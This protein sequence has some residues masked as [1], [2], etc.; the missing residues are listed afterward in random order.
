MDLRASSRLAKKPRLD[1]SSMD[2]SSSYNEEHVVKRL[3]LDLEPV[4]AEPLEAEPLETAPAETQ[5]IYKSNYPFIL[6][7]SIMILVVVFIILDY[8]I[9]KNTLLSYIVPSG[10]SLYSY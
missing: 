1:Y 10:Y 9:F 3:R 8:N 4:E 6:L 2:G 7:D 5:I